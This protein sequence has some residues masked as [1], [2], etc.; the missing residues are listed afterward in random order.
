M[1]ATA[2][3]RI[4]V[5]VAAYQ[6]QATLGECLESLVRLDY[7]RDRLEIICVDNASTDDTPA[8]AHAFEPR[9]RVLRAERR[10]AAAARNVGIRAASGDVVAFTD[11][12]CTVDPAWVREL[13]RPLARRE[14]GVAGGRILARRPCNAIER[15]GERL[16]DHETAITRCEPPY[17]IT[18]NW[19]SPRSV[20][21]DVDGF[22]ERLLRCQDVDLAYR[23]MKRGLRLAYVDEAVIHHR[24]ERTLAGLVREG[25]VHGYNSRIVKKLHRNY[26][27]AY[28][29]DWTPRQR[30]AADLRELVRAPSHAASFLH[31]MFDT[32]KIFGEI[33]ARVRNEEA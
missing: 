5:V 28:P 12:D 32:G 33:H 25:Y 31:L 22:D 17:A 1:S 16:H 23:M 29:P 9:V 18:M 13:V 6:A 30:L 19:A 27:Q 24:N 7:P 2:V 11:A 8:V 20:L 21:N 15:F 10:G 3:P 14:V 4:T 26:L